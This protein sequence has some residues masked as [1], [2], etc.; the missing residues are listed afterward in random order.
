MLDKTISEVGKTLGLGDSIQTIAKEL[1]LK[2]FDPKAGGFQAFVDR[3]AAVSGTDLSHYLAMFNDDLARMPENDVSQVLGLDAISKIASSCS[4]NNASVITAASA[5][6]PK[7]LNYI[8]PGG[9]IDT[10][11]PAA[12]SEYSPALS[13]MAGVH[14]SELINPSPLAA[15]IEKTVIFDPVPPTVSQRN[16][17]TPVLVLA[18]LSWFGWN[19]INKNSTKVATHIEIDQKVQ[20]SKFTDTTSAPNQ[21]NR[22]EKNEAPSDSAPSDSARAALSPAILERKPQDSGPRFVKS[23]PSRLQINNLSG[24]ITVAGTVSDQT[25]KDAILFNLKDVFGTQ[26]VSGDLEIDE[27]A[28]PP[29]WTGKLSAVVPNLSTPGLSISMI[30]DSIKIGGELPKATL[31]TLMLKIKDSLGQGFSIAAEL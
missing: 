9:V 10:N 12:I 17:I 3:L 24:K 30:G 26:N 2:I 13:Q 1:L 21:E 20:P 6:L 28:I 18:L 29:K 27:R 15:S 22:L 5:L 23:V 25:T 16:W 31:N 4:I 7:L 8:A 11:I 19:W 14:N